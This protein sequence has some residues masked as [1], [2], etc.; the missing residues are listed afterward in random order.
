MVF[1]PFH[2][3]EWFKLVPHLVQDQGW[4]LQRQ[5]ASSSLSFCSCPWGGHL[6]RV[7]VVGIQAD[8]Q[9]AHHVLRPELLMNQTEL[10]ELVAPG[11]AFLRQPTPWGNKVTSLL[12]GAEHFEA[13]SDS[14]TVVHRKLYRDLDCADCAVSFAERGTNLRGLLL[15]R[16][17]DIGIE[18]MGVFHVTQEQLDLWNSVHITLLLESAERFAHT[19]LRNSE[20]AM[21]QQFYR[22]LTVQSCKRGLPLVPLTDDGVADHQPTVT[23]AAGKHAGLTRW[24][25][26]EPEM[27]EKH[28]FNF[29]DYMR[30]FL[31]NLGETGV[32]VFSSLEGRQLVPYQCS[33]DRA[34]WDSARQKFTE[35][36]LLQK[37]AYRRANGGSTAP[38][39]HED[40][41][42]RF[43]PDEAA[44]AL[45]Q[46]SDKEPKPDAENR[47]RRRHKVVVRR[48]FLDVEESS[49]EVCT[50][51]QTRRP[52]TT[53]ILPPKG[54]VM[55]FA[56]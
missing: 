52:K 11:E 37:T 19:F 20:R 7:K 51:R 29:A 15:C 23:I 8:I 12:F 34:A 28:R 6:L 36:F 10:L 46:L 56:Y 48:T 13:G 1:A 30:L 27:Q 25:R 40:V 33:V 26:Y 17:Q 39:F 38:S 24:V 53:S 45:R 54:E 44:V 49:D 42:A 35:A 18:L 4:D 47:G 5:E 32:R 43:I 16:L 22:V 50:T 21:D 9:N 41:K 31:A 2:L 3:G 55:A 14:W